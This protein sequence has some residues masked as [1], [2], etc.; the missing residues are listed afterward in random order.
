VANGGTAVS[1]EK[2]SAAA[3]GGSSAQSKAS[4]W[5]VEDT[6]ANKESRAEKR[7]WGWLTQGVDVI[8]GKANKLCVCLHVFW[9]NHHDKLCDD[10]EW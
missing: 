1:S 5:L 3:C 9:R 6:V 4:T 8:V 7:A 2:T 10:K